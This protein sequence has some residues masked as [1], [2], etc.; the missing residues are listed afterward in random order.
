MNQSPII[1]ANASRIAAPDGAWMSGADVRGLGGAGIR[2]AVDPI[3][4]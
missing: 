3:L 2:G 1:F 4:Q